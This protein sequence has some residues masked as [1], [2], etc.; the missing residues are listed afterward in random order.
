MHLVFY[1]K[2]VFKKLDK[3][4]LNSSTKVLSLNDDMTLVLVTQ[5]VVPHYVLHHL[6]CCIINLSL[7]LASYK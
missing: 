2:Y 1:E 4:S 3:Q 5:L 6:A 7:Y